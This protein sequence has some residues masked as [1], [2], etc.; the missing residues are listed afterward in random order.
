MVDALISYLSSL[1][2][3]E[4]ASALVLGSHLA[5]CSPEH[6]RLA[7]AAGPTSDDINALVPIPVYLVRCRAQ[8]PPTP[9]AGGPSEGGGRSVV[10]AL[11]GRTPTSLLLCKW[12]LA[13]AL[14]PGDCVRLVHMPSG[15][16]PKPSAESEGGDVDGVLSAC[17]AALE[18]GGVKDVR[19]EVLR[20]WLED[21]R[22]AL[23]DLSEAGDA[24]A[25]MIL[26]SRGPS[27]L[28]RATLG[29]VCSYCVQ[30]AACSLAIV[31][32]L[33]LAGAGGG[34]E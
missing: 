32:P 3:G 7:A 5:A 9:G 25:L 18:E 13:N 6:K 31:P 29:S 34:K 24:P 11:D 26:A 27:A 23:V 14:R 4:E 22:D 20:D 10:I 12:A 16:I 21:A 28:K 30:H 8:I 33:A 2:E 19:L 17:K 15:L 1:G